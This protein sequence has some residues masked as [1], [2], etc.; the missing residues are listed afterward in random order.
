MAIFQDVYVQIR[1]AQ[2]VKEWLR[3]A[4]RIIFTHESAPLS[5][6]LKLTESLW[7]ALE[8]RDSTECWTLASTTQ[9]LDQILMHLHGCLI[10]E[11]Y[12]LHQLGLEEL[13]P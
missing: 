5:P 12:T 4:W 7:D 8:E 10:N 13:L 6:D 9:D 2:T 1:Q 11:S 3:G